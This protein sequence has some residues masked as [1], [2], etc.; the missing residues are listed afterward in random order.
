MSDANKTKLSINVWR[1]AGEIN[2]SVSANQTIK[3]DLKN[4]CYK[5][6]S[7]A[8]LVRNKRGYTGR[9]LN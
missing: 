2:I 4:L 6:T 5:A 1:D 9:Y 3:K 8:I 7:V